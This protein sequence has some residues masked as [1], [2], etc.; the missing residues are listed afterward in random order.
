MLIS[1]GN[2]DI[3]PVPKS[4]AE[5]VRP[6]TAS[7]HK[8]NYQELSTM[9]ESKVTFLP[10]VCQ[11][12]KT[13]LKC[14]KLFFR[15]IKYSEKQWSNARHCSRRCGAMLRDLSNDKIICSLYLDGK[16]CSDIAKIYNISAKHVSRIIKENGGDVDMYKIKKG[17]LH[18]TEGG[19]IRFDDSKGNGFHSGRRLH[20]LIAEM[21][22]G[23]PLFKNEVVHHKDNDKLNNHPDNLVVMDRGEHTLLHLMKNN[24]IKLTDMDVENIRK[25]YVKGVRTQ[26]EI[27]E[28]YGVDKSLI[29]NI[30]AGRAR[31]GKNV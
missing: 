8:A 27:A 3:I 28:S 13:C 14:G 4:K 30:L 6:L 17:G 5:S 26:R 29:G 18:I 31:S 1:R 2:Y 15:N 22:I 21:S 19:Y 12:S 7:N 24:K 16:S 25:N 10:V 9:T 20:I 23:R 11:E